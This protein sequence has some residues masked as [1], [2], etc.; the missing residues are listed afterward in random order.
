MPSDDDTDK[1]SGGKDRTKFT[2][3]KPTGS[4]PPVN[5]SSVDQSSVSPTPVSQSSGITFS[6][7]EEAI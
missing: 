6:Q 1:K 2:E 7:V 3:E 5:Q 4:Q